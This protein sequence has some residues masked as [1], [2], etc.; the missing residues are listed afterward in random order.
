MEPSLEFGKLTSGRGAASAGRALSFFH[1][2]KKTRG[3]K[4]F[5]N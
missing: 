5:K 3:E 4:N 2:E 1:R